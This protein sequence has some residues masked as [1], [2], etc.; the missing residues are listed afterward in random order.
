MRR[1]G[2]VRARVDGEVRDL[3]EEIELDKY[4]M[5]TIEVVV[6]RLVIRHVGDAQ[7]SAANGTAHG[8][9]ASTSRLKLV[10]ESRTAYTT[11]GEQKDTQKPSGGD[12]GLRA[13]VADSVETTLKLG[14]G[15]ILVS[16]VGGEER[17]YSEKFACVYCG[18]SLDELAP[19]NFSFNSPH[20]ACPE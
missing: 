17:M 7:D 16:V 4:K 19:R 14:G 10:A 12:D 2:Y 5:H 3:S 11:G 18:I 6:D 20:G 9:G 15:V 8:V 13:R 1:A